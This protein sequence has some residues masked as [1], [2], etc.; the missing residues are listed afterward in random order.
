MS[1]LQA[2]HRR[3][4]AS[5]TSSSTKRKRSSRANLPQQE[6]DE[7][8]SEHD[9]AW[10]EKYYATSASYDEVKAAV[11]DMT[12]QG[13]PFTTALYAP[14]EL[15]RCSKKL[16]HLFG[17]SGSAALDIATRSKEA[18]LEY[19]PYPVETL[20]DLDHSKFIKHR[21][22]FEEDLNNSLVAGVRGRPTM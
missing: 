22:Q 10:H 2:S 13:I 4:L 7:E 3:A 21:K 1:S 5:P 12:D 14:S 15:P 18:G 17:H 8:D 11:S 9:E 20:D 16:Y 6:D 19:I